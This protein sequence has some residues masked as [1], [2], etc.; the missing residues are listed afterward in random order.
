MTRTANN[1]FATAAALLLTVVT[2]QQ[3]VTVPA[4]AA[5]IAT[6]QLA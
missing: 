6:A 3:T 2:F 1:I 4:Q 5:P